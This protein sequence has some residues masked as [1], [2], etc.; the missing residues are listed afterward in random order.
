MISILTVVIM[1][2]SLYAQAPSDDL[3]R[4]DFTVRNPADRGVQTIARVSVP[5]PRGLILGA[6]PATATIA[7]KATAGQARVITTHPDGSARRIMLGLPVDLARRETVQGT[8]GPVGDEAPEPSILTVGRASRIQATPYTILTRDGSLQL[9]GGDGRVLCVVRPFGPELG[10]PAEA[11]GP[12]VLDDGPHF[13]WLR[14]LTEGADWC[15]EVDLQADRSGRLRLVHRLQRRQAGDAWTPDFGFELSV[16]GGRVHTAPDGPVHFMALDPRSSF[17]D[18]PELVASIGLA[19]DALISVA[20][21][22]ALRQNRGTL[23]AKAEAGGVAIRSS[24]LEPVDDLE[25]NGLMIQE[26]QW[27]VSELVIGPLPGEALASVIDDPLETHASWRAYDAVYH[28]GPPL[29]VK[30]ELL[31]R[32]VEKHIHAMQMMSLDGDDWGNMTGWW[33]GLDRPPINSMVRYNHC[34]Y[35]W[36]DFFRTG[37][38]RLY[39]IASDW[40]ENYRNLSVYWGPKTEYYGGGR[41]GRAWRDR[42]G[43]PHGPGTY[44]VRHDL[45]Q[46]FTTK[47][48]HSFWLAYEETGDPRFREAAE[49]QAR[50]S[51]ENVRCDTGEMR[52]VG[53]IADFVK[54]HEYTGETHYLDEAVRLWEEFRSKQGDDLLFTQSGRPAVGDHLYIP[55]DDYGYKH[56]FVKPY[57]VQYATNALPYLLRHRPD[58]KRLRD[59]IL[60]LNHWMA[61]VQ[62]PGGGWGY[63]APTTAGLS[64]SIEY[65]HGMMLACGIEPREAYLEAVQRDL[66]P[67]AQL[68]ELHGEIPSGLNPWESLVGINAAKRAEI[69][70]LATD[71]DAYK[72]FTGGQ[73]RFGHSPDSTVYFQVVLRDYLKYRSE[74]SLL[75]SDDV[76]DQIKRLPTT[77]P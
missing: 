75:Q 4:I 43:S 25:N 67:R 51:A 24:R 48:F 72:D 63:P 9:V 36:E 32:A 6:P 3:S 55:D 19:N 52:N 15:R 49:A 73:V 29:A 65:D 34:Q 77:L 11:E 44:M 60:A 68:M 17:A 2:L 31:E 38:R 20:N 39:D 47:G 21:P 50:W 74:E 40:S 35:V 64:W 42:P 56:P 76:L 33:P 12:A 59:T 57:I 61:R 23:E 58:D 37:D 22:L 10:R 70:H 30:A 27:R 53:M 8:Y 16:P 5:V 69:Y 46:S 7:G 18:H 71:R 13:V 54:L 41:R 45:A 62:S 14:W 1:S 66:R 28:T 26:G